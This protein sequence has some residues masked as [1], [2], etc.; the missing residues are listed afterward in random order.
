MEKKQE[1]QKNH[2]ISFDVSLRHQS[3]NML[4]VFEQC[5]VRLVEKT[6]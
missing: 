2:R 5:R 6:A 1:M 3:R 4:A